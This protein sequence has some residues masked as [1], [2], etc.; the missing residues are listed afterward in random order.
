MRITAGS[1]EQTEAFYQVVLDSLPN[2]VAVVDANGRTRYSNAAWRE[3]Y[4][5]VVAP[6]AE[7]LMREGRYLEA[8]E[9]ALTLDIGAS[10][11]SLSLMRT[12]LAALRNIIAGV[13]DEFAMEYEVPGQGRWFRV[14]LGRSRSGNGDIVIQ[15]E[16]ITVEKHAQLGAEN[17]RRFLQSLIDLL[18]TRILWKDTEGRILGANRAFLD[19]AGLANVV[20]RTDMDLPWAPGEAARIRGDD[21]RVMDGGLPE[22]NVE[23]EI[24]RQ[25]GGKRWFREDRMPLLRPDGSTSG[26][27]VAY[28]DIT[29]LKRTED[30]L[31][32]HMVELKASEQRLRATVES[33][34]LGL[35]ESDLP[36]GEVLLGGGWCPCWACRPRTPARR[37][38]TTRSA[39]TPT[40]SCGSAPAPGR[41]PCRAPTSST[42]NTGCATP[43][44]GGSGSTMAAG[45]SSASRTASRCGSSA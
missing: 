26:I 39:C 5:G 10:A 17:T 19:D 41:R 31:A 36:S 7:Q 21:Q 8:C 45:W 24:T 33:A 38:R 30:S 1:A 13:R 29:T 37:S 16:N 20:G 3:H 43:T 11:D 27:L 9:A 15:R 25:D 4:E 35:Y 40:T 28:A 34:E 44:A 12:Y 2:Q 14:R 23:R 18:P 22:F 42:W 6:G 32:R